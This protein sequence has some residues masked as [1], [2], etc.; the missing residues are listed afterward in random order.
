MALA[1]WARSPPRRSTST[2][3]TALSGPVIRLVVRT[4]VSAANTAAS[5]VSA[6]TAA[7]V[8]VPSSALR[9]CRVETRSASRASKSRLAVTNAW[10]RVLPTVT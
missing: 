10:N 5:R 4:A 6:P 2:A 1:R 9:L 8:T 3:T 7:T